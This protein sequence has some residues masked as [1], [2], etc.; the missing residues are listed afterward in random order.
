MITHAKNNIYLLSKPLFIIVF[1]LISGMQMSVYAQTVEDPDGSVEL[2]NQVKNL[3]RAGNWAAGKKLVDEGMK[4]YPKESDLKML[5]GRYYHQ[6][7][8][9]DKARYE[10]K[11]SLEWN[12]KNVDA[13]QILVN[14]EQESKRYSS[15]ICYVNELLEV[16]PYW[17]GLWSR[18]IELYELQGNT[19][20]SNRLRKRLSQIYPKDSKVQEDY[21]YNTELQAN[22]LRKQGK[23]DEAISLTSDLLKKQPEN[24]SHY[25]TLVNDHLKTGDYYSALAFAE[26]GLIQFPGNLSLINKKSG[27]LAE[28]K[29]Y[30]EL[31]P[32][33]QDQMKFGNRAALQQQY[34][35]YLLEAARSAKDKDPAT[36]YG[37]IFESS[38]GNYEA[39]N[40]VFNNAVGNQQYEEALA[41]LNRYRRARGG[42][43]N[44]SMKELMVHTRMGNTSRAEGLTK[45][46]F[47]QYPGDTDLKAAYVKILNE[48]AKDLMAQHAYN[49][50]IPVLEMIKRYGD[51]ESYKS[52]Q[53]A[54]FTAYL[55]L[56]DYNN[57]LNVL[58]DIQQNE[59][60]NP[61]LYLKKADLY[62]NLKRYDMALA[63]Y[64]QAFPQISEEEKVKYLGSYGDMLTTIV[65]DLNE[66]YRYDEA[67]TYV[68]RWLENDPI[69]Q[70]ALHYAVN[71]S[72]Q[73]KNMDEMKTYAQRGADA[74]PDDIFFKLKL[75]EVDGLDPEKYASI[76][77]DLQTE[78]LE[79]P[80]H[81]DAIKSF[82]VVSE[83]Y[84]NQLIKNSQ[85][86]QALDVLNNALKY[87]P[88][89]KDLKY[90]KGLA[91][92]KLKQYDSAYVYQKYYEP[93]LLELKEFRDHM[94]FLKY[95][96]F[97]NEI[98][99]YHLRSRFAD[100]DVITTISTLEY[101]KF[102]IKDTYIGRINYTGR[103]SGKG[104]QLQAEWQ[105]NWDEKTRSKIDAAWANQFFP[106]IAA[107]A[108]IYRDLMI[109]KGIEGELGVGYRKLYEGG[110]LMNIVVGAT[111]MLEPW[112]LNLRVN[113]YFLDGQ[114]LYNVSTN[115]R[116][117]L[118]SPKNY[119]VALGSIGSSPDVDLINYQLHNGF[120]VTNSMVGAGFSHLLTNS[121]ST[122]ILGTWNH[123]KANN[124]NFR[125]LYNIYMNLNVSF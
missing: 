93:S 41:I 109:L 71:L 105:R 51:N 101:S 39:F 100:I 4:K 57:A 59:P 55:E 102:G 12:A 47:A 61:L 111:K 120:S 42:S 10:L 78:L 25:L 83:K 116:Y 37:K 73:R 104:F 43:K 14:V 2:A 76:Y 56:K 22:A 69:N 46:L 96:S 16:N 58:N 103:D 99:L 85:S 7:K 113:N 123:Y 40:Y 44:L 53:N 48:E 63:S 72:A 32:F 38:P 81:Q 65:K 26:R 84:G 125:S 124:V 6:M 91:F 36:L 30:D 19:V 29:R 18:K 35:Y 121:V 66:Q 27:I 97:H 64:E 70:T 88:E 118:T 17:K 20:E 92:E 8:Q 11:K 28:Q 75:M 9:Y 23:I 52:A 24:P 49:E 95:K 80:Y 13:K 68:Q 119:I 90:T 114:W 54:L 62:Y 74:H 60:Y 117:Y 89:N 110:N 45:Q 79:N 86:Q 34:N 33:L 21:L 31:I 98:G 1:L 82:A 94:N 122:G 3:Y 107:N 5:S 87:A 15:A 50:A 67:M 112:R 77:S 115:V 106:T 108:S